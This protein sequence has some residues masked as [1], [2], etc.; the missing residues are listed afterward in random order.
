MEHC[1]GES[2]TEGIGQL[3]VRQRGCV[4]ILTGRVSS[5]ALLTRL[6]NL[7]IK[8]EG[9]ALVEIYRMRFDDEDFDGEEG[10]AA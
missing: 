4:V 7:A 10:F 9:A 8:V 5:R 3:K 6:V 1:I 2:V